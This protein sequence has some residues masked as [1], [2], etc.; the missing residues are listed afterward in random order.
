MKTDDL[1][2]YRIVT[3]SSHSNPAMRPAYPFNHRRNWPNF[4]AK[5][6]KRIFRLIATGAERQNKNKNTQH[7]WNL[8]HTVAQLGFVSSI[9]FNYG[10]HRPFGTRLNVI[11]IKPKGVRNAEITIYLLSG[12]EHAE[13]PTPIQIGWPQNK[14]R[15]IAQNTNSVNEAGADP[16]VAPTKPP[17]RATVNIHECKTRYGRN[18]SVILIYFNANPKPNRMTS[19]DS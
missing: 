8:S 2:V 6:Q 3:S 7:Y 12:A 18:C 11:R 19:L 14:I 15:Y 17:Q 10:Q 16:I 4:C 13:K 9:F 1:P 5:A